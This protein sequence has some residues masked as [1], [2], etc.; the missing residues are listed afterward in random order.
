MSFYDSIDE[1][2]EKRIEFL[3]SVENAGGREC[4]SNSRYRQ[5]GRST[6]IIFETLK[7]MSLYP[8]VRVY[9]YG[10]TYTIANSIKNRLMQAS[11]EFNVPYSIMIAQQVGK[12]NKNVYT[13][14]EMKNLII[15]GS[16][17]FHGESILVYD[18]TCF[19]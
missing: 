1:Y 13:A 18:H 4:L 14:S 15:N 10:K 19:E 11:K 6:R 16:V 9:I 12:Y 3:Q 2:V 17:E 8:C 5:T 7:Q